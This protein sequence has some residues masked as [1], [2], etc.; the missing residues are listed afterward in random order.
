MPYNQYCVGTS[1]S[2]LF[3]LVDHDVFVVKELIIRKKV[4]FKCISGNWSIDRAQSNNPDFD[5]TF[6]L[7]HLRQLLLRQKF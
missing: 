7:I 2:Q 5:P 1:F 6:K 3:T 4:V